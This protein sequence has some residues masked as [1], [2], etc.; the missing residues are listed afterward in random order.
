MD[1]L[2]SAWLSPVLGI[3]LPDAWKTTSRK[4]LNKLR[5]A[6]TWNNVFYDLMLTAA[7]RYKLEG[8]PDTMDERVCIMSLLWYGRLLIFEK[9]GA[10]Y[11]LPCV[12]SSDGFTVYGEWRKAR[13]MA[14][15]GASEEVN[16]YIPGSSS[17]LEKT[18]LGGEVLSSP[19]GVLIRENRA[20]YP[21][22]TYVMQWA[23]YITDTLRTLDTARRHLKHPTV[24]ASPQS[25]VKTF[26]GRELDI[27][28]NQD[29][30]V[31]PGLYKDQT[32]VLNLGMDGIT[33]EVRELYEWYKGQFL[34]MCGIDHN[35]QGD[36]KG[37]NLLVDE[38]TID[39]ENDN[40]NLTRCMNS[41]QEGLDFANSIFGT[42]I[43]VTTDHKQEN[44]PDQG[45]RE[46]EGGEEDD[47]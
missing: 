26:A 20:M 24:I 16:L 22:I 7:E 43:T 32:Q 34:G 39:N 36:K 44:V 41:I 38:V 46:E 33:T 29:V 4:K 14:L 45:R 13:W 30:L 28:D 31:V 27:D 5:N 47:L 2:T 10:L 21:F 6:R 18:V 23:D 8:L 17:F 37:A 12:N 19:S 3:P 42:H 9:D 11:G 1:I 15:N 25:S 40:T 35:S